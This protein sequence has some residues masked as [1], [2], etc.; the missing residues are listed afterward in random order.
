MNTILFFNGATTTYSQGKYINQ[1]R[2]RA[3]YRKDEANVCLSC[4]KDGDYWLNAGKLVSDALLES[5]NIEDAKRESY[6]VLESAL[7]SEID[8]YKELIAKIKE[9]EEAAANDK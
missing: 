7:E 2:H 5:D 8:Y 6:E 4:D 1:D 3:A 9:I